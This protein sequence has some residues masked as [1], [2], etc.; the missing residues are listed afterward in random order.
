[1]KKNS[2]ICTLIMITKANI[3]FLLFIVMFSSCTEPFDLAPQEKGKLLVEC[4]LSPSRQVFANVQVISNF[5]DVNATLYPDDAI[6]RLTSGVDEE[7]K[8]IYDGKSRSYY[9]PREFRIDPAKNYR[10]AVFENEKEIEYLE[11]RSSIPSPPALKLNEI[12]SKDIVSD[13]LKKQ[14]EVRVLASMPKLS[15]GK[16]GFVRVRAF[17]KNINGNIEYLKFAGNDEE[18]LAFHTCMHDEH[19][20]FDLSRLDNNKFSLRFQTQK[21]FENEKLEKIFIQ[22]ESIS[23]ASFRYNLSKSK[24][25]T[26]EIYGI[27]DPVT[28]Y[29][30]ASNGYGYLGAASSIT[31][32]SISIN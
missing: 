16:N 29:T 24:K 3:Y 15:N 31:I 23:E 10:I 12:E 21:M 11:A 5:T 28:N 32:D 2:Q 17:R 14:K 8:F 26:A 6:I 25:M 22:Y 4:E 19:T 1:M 20:I 13:K 9:L 7:Y 27:S 18:P 30:N